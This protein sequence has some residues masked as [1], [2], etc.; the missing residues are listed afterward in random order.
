[1][2]VRRAALLALIGLSAVACGP[3]SSAS[4]AAISPSPPAISTTPS[5]IGSSPPAASGEPSRTTTSWGEI[6]D[7]LPPGFPQFPGATATATTGE[8]VSGQLTVPTEPAAA[9]NW[10]TFAL[11]QGGY[12]IE[13]AEGP[14]EDQ[15]RIVH[16]VGTA[17]G[18]RAQ[19][20]LKPLGGTTIASIL[21]GTGCPFS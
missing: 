7:A 1:M 21:L 11:Q 14:L 13:S 17:P 19:V 6:W 16:A 4:P 15:S 8:P 9:A 2:H 20:T 12:R 5:P 3:N 18:C 10:W